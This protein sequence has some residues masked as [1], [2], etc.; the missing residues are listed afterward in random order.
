[1]FMKTALRL[2]IALSL[3]LLFCLFGSFNNKALANGP[4]VGQHLSKTVKSGVIKKGPGL[5][6]RPFHETGKLLS[7]SQFCF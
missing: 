7:P 3:L 5:A 6:E 1:M 4:G 2:L